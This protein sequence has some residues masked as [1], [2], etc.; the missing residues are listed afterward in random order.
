MHYTLRR[1]K[2]IANKKLV[3]VIYFL[4]VFFIR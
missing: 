1:E 3:V 2:E 4:G